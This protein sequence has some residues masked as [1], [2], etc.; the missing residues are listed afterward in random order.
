VEEEDLL[1]LP[2]EGSVHNTLWDA[3]ELRMFSALSSLVLRRSSHLAT[4]SRSSSMA[5]ASRPVLRG[6]IFDMD[7]TLTKP[8]LDFTEMY[9]RVGSPLVARGK[10][11]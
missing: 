8:N 3:R 1:L 5:T 7:G 9:R 2:L 4:V 6:V 10:C 11:L